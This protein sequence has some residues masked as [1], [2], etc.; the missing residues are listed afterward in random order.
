MNPIIRFLLTGLI[1]FTA[2]GA[3]SAQEPPLERKVS[4]ELDGATLDEALNTIMNKT[5]VLFLY[6]SKELNLTGPYTFSMTDVPVSKVLDRIIA[7]KD[8]TYSTSGG[9]IILKKKDKGTEAA[10]PK[11]KA[12]HGTVVDKTGIGVIGATVMV[13]G[14][15]TGTSTDL[16]GNF[17]LEAPEGSLIDIMIIGYRTAT[18]KAQPGAHLSIILEEDVT[19]L[20]EVVVVGYGTQK[21]INMTGS[22]E[23]VGGEKMENM[24]MPSLSRG[25]QGLIP[26]L[27][28]DM[29]DGKPIRSS[30]YNVRGTTSIGEGGGSTLILIDGAPGD[31]D[32]LNPNDIESVTVLKDAASAAIY[33]ARGPFGVVLITTKN[34]AEGKTSVSYSGNVSFYRQT[35]TNDYIWDGY[36]YLTQFV[37][38]Y[39]AYN[40]YAMNP[41]GVNN[42]FPFTQGL[43]TYMAE[44]KK[45]HDDPTLSKV[46]T[47]PATGKYIYYGST[48][49]YKELYKDVNMGTEHS[50]NISGSAKNVGYYISG[51]YY[52]QDGIFRYNS[53]DYKMFNVRGKGYVQVAPW[54]KISNNFD[55]S[56]RTYNYPL[57][58]IYEKGIWRNIADQGFPMAMMFN[59][60]GTL[61]R[62][63]AYTV[64]DFYTGN[65]KSTTKQFSLR[66]TTNLTATF[67][68]NKLR[69]NADFT[70]S[71]K[72]DQDKRVLYPVTFSDVPGELL[73]EGTN[74][75]SLKNNETSYIGT[76]I[77]GEYEQT[78]NEDHYFKAM[79]G[80]NYEYNRLTAHYA[81]RNGLLKP[82][83]ADFNLTNGS[84]AV[85]TGGG[86]T[87][88]IMGVFTR[89]NYIY[90]ERYLVEINARYD[91]SSVF[92]KNSRFGMFPSISAGWRVSKESFWRV[93]PKAISEFKVRASYGELGNGQVP[94]YSYTQTIGTATASRIIN[95]TLPLYAV[96]PSL[97]PETL[98]WERSKTV[99]VGMDMAFLNN[100]LTA[101]IDVYQRNTED[102]YTVGVIVPSVLG[103]SSPK[104]NYA[105]LRTRGFEFSIEWKDR[106]EMVKPLDYSLRFVLSDSQ[107]EITRYNNPNGLI[108]NVYYVGAQVGEIWGY[109]IEGLFQSEEEIAAH[110]DQ[111]YMKT[112]QGQK[113]WLPG[114]MKY[115]DLDKSGK[116]NDGKKTIADP[117]DM[118]VIGNTTP[119]W[120]YG[121][122]LS[123]NWNGFFATAMFQGVGK[124]D[125]YPSVECNA[126]WG[127]YN[128]P[129]NMLPTHVY[130]NQWSED[131]P[132]GYFPRLRGYL[133]TSTNG[134]LRMPNTRYLQNAAYIRLKNLSFGYEFPSA[135]LEKAKISKLSVYFSGQNLWTWSPIHRITKNIDPEVISGSDAEVASGKGD[136]N[137]YPMLKNFTLGVTIG[138]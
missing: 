104:G 25:L 20:E 133:A 137:A 5:G 75:L 17:S 15:S 100:R 134:V 106:I 102:M 14:S 39:N 128:R 124:R 85:I 94:P 108:E 119:R 54:L 73:S 96:Q 19:L 42:A 33:G 28:I 66:N 32:M 86:Q 136:S 74:K 44:L 13:K 3:L 47:D 22:V 82:E 38:A 76:N 62:H 83:I 126:F 95:G 7:G 8:V 70:Y 2:G 105:D 112:S 64:G 127:M 12:T 49:W 118:S 35:Q 30:E 99:N 107:A 77:Y 90:K 111:S 36:T 71:F 72:R 10:P 53:D 69:L 113:T 68:E 67:F 16:D 61:T 84:N 45:R 55:F 125:W 114:D 48:D 138:F 97:I 80:F 89:L 37:E 116:I 101:N 21:K 78:F 26:N 129:Y 93:D 24:P 121:I 120:R 123:A 40:D 43:E 18:V 115:K 4:I 132:D 92:P 65:N 103:T 50:I 29:A 23:S 110:A 131:N 88:A 87:W 109:T 1:L 52:G 60:D 98:T 63:A 51:R 41:T 58:S 6:K 34:P 59:P 91:G 46:E 122:N 11:D 81:E 57:T 135:W 130:E 27:N 31:P 79:A 56:N 9:Q 117:G